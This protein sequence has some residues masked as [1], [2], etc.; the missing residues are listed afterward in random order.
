MEGW[1]YTPDRMGKGG[2]SVEGVEG[3]RERTR[4]PDCQ[5]VE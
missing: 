1:G 3:R 2:G 5:V 4:A